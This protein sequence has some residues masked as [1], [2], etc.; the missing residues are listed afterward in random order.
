MMGTSAEILIM[1]DHNG[2]YTIFKAKKPSQICV[3][4]NGTLESI[5]EKDFEERFKCKYTESIFV[6]D[7]EIVERLGSLSKKFE[8][9][10]IS[11]YERD[12]L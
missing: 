9:V 6:K 11:D 2:P 4:N 12:L 5:P 10:L 8:R 1:R 3:F 7:Y